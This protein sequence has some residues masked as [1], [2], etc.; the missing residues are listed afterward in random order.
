M[1][2]ISHFAERSIL[3]TA[4][5]NLAL[6]IAEVVMASNESDNDIY[7]SVQGCLFVVKEKLIMAHPWILSKMLTSDIPWE[8]PSEGAQFFVDVDPTSFRLILA[9]LNGTLD[10]SRDVH[11]L[12]GADLALL[13]ATSRYLLLEDIEQKIEQVQAGFEKELRAKEEALDQL[14][15]TLQ[16]FDAMKDSMQHK[17]MK[18]VT[19]KA[20]QTHRPYNQCGC[21]SIVIG[22]LNP[23]E[24]SAEDD[25]PCGRCA[26]D[27]S[28]LYGR[29]NQITLES[30]LS[31]IEDFAWALDHSDI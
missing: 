6:D 20:Y 13:K 24:C 17:S 18:V 15:Q 2:S 12:S 5:T 26:N 7:L 1:L 9:I 27:R 8:K 10:M 3:T 16:M 14:R 21:Q 25:K 22:D 28:R 31:H 29:H 23:E 4:L 30:T 19:C 11:K